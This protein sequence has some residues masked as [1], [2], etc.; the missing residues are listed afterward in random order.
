MVEC[1][2][3]GNL[4]II[5][6][7]AD[8]RHVYDF[9]PNKTSLKKSYDVIF[10][11]PDFRFWFWFWWVWVWFWEG[12]TRKVLILLYFNIETSFNVLTDPEPE[13]VPEPAIGARVKRRVGR[14]RF[15]L[16]KA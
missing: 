1:L 6:R 13:P 2:S 10:F 3:G 5:Y 11:D 12:R 9:E 7:A 14:V 8:G 4:A 15:R 16:L